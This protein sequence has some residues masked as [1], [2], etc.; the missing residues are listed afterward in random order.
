MRKSYQSGSE[1]TSVPQGD[2]AHLNGAGFGA[3]GYTGYSNGAAGVGET[4]HTAPYP[5][6]DDS[7]TYDRYG[8]SPGYQMSNLGE[9]TEMPGEVPVSGVARNY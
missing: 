4:S 8:N 5:M 2:T 7:G 9:R 3:G 6:D 1:A